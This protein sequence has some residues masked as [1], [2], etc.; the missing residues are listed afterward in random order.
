M[1]KLKA[2]GRS[3]S[4]STSKSSSTKNNRQEKDKLEPVV[5]FRLT[6]HDAANDNTCGKL[7]LSSKASC[8]LQNF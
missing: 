3:V 5:G 7:V 4:F 1:N 6:L 2:I 8:S